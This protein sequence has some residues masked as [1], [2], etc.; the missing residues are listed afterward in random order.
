M[1]V[2]ALTSSAVHCQTGE[3]KVMAE[4]S[5]GTQ[6]Q[7]NRDANRKRETEVEEREMEKKGSVGAKKGD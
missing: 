5:R 4:R 1:D 3:D 7:N 6:S 2:D